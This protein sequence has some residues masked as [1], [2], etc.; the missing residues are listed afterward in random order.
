MEAIKLLLGLCS[1]FALA[2]CSGD[3]V[4]DFMPGTYVNSAGGEFS[5]ASDTLTVELLE[6]NNYKIFRSTGFN[7]I[8]DGKLGPREIEAEVWTCAYSGATKTLTEL[9][10]GKVISFFPEKEALVIGRRLYKKINQ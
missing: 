6:G 8:S 1:C 7:I 9:K 2:S 10:K 4:R 5:M 3:K